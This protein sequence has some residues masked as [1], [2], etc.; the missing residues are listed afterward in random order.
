MTWAD[1]LRR[2]VIAA[3]LVAACGQSASALDST[4]DVGQYAHTAWRFRDGFAQGQVTAIAQTPDGYLWLGSEFGLLRFDGVRSVPWHPPGGER[5]PSNWV[6][7]LLA[8]RDGTLW[9]GTLEGLASWRNGTLTLYPKLAGQSVNA[10]LEDRA[11]TIWAGGYAGG[12][13][14]VLSSTATLC[15]ITNHRTECHGGDFGQW[16]GALHERRN[17][18]LWA[19]AETGLWRLRPGAPKHFAIPESAGSI[20]QTLIDDP[21]GGL[22]VATEDGILQLVDGE[23]IAYRLPGAQSR[24]KPQRLLRDRDGG[25]WIGTLDRGLLHVHQGRTDVYTEANGLSGD[26][27]TR[28]FEDREGNIW[29]AT[30]NGLDRFRELAVRTIST[31]QGLQSAAPW[32]VLAASDGSIWMGTMDGVS[33]WQAGQVTTY[34]TAGNRPAMEVLPATGG[35]ERRDILDSGLPDDKVGALFEDR[36]GR[37]WVSTLRGVAYLAN[38]RFVPVRDLPGGRT[39]LMVGDDAGDLWIVN[40]ALGLFRVRGETVID[41]TPWNTLGLSTPPTALLPDSRHGGLWLGL[42]GRVVYIADTRIRA[43]YAVADG[44]AGGRVNDLRLDANGMLWVA[45]ERGLSRIKDGRVV[46]VTSSNDLPCDAVHWSMEDTDR[47]IWLYMTCGLV[48]IAS[49][50][51]KATLIDPTRRIETRVFAASDGVGL[52]AT[53]A[54]YRPQVARTTDGRLWFLPGDGVSVLDVR[55]MSINTLPPPVHIERVTADR[56]TYAVTSGL[57]LP[58]LTRDLEID[59]TALSF[60]APEMNR[61]RVKLEGRDRHWRDVENRRQVFYTDLSPGAYRFRVAASNNSGVWNETGGVLEFSVAPAY[62][63]TTW[64]QTV[65]VVGAL[66]LCW[67]VYRFR[68]RQLAH[69]FN[70]RLD[71]RVHERTRIAR[72]LHDTLLQSFHGLLLRFQSARDLLPANPGRAVEALDGALDRADQ[73]ITEGRDA[74]QNL[75]SSAAV[76]SELTQAFTALAEELGSHAGGG[77]S[78]AMFRLSVEGRPRELHPIVGDD[79]HRIAREALRNAFYHA[80]A[81][82]IEV[83]VTYGGREL[84]LRIRDDGRGIDLTHLN[85]ERARHWGLTGMRERAGQIG[86]H[87]DLWSEAG[88]GTEVE[89]RVPGALAYRAPH[90]DRHVLRMLRMQ[91][92]GL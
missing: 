63:Q 54:L 85:A 40:D 67:A 79:I 3:G 37:V 90:G 27:I 22:L 23:T 10:L 77:K 74:I 35:A 87:L 66:A 13:G 83:E 50:E 70:L 78:S 11:G 57:Q 9:I 38:G 34:R 29:V 69:D 88:A 72:E 68:L 92:D 59:Y 1:T 53:P 89:L 31:N 7:S 19:T 17:G 51:L 52:R 91:R 41:R 64:F 25:L 36:A 48:R 18:D 82:H 55:N 5:L 62:Y 4:L 56:R 86:A 28:L 16:V 21:D 61:F 73:A 71:E 47:A 42:P 65:G 58:P 44:L 39:S 32:S 6:R 84:R 46:T 15:A 24:F 30:K 75:R 33:R 14:R 76:G 45:M 81:T 12:L 20:L 8:T 2:A 49:A 60:V 43:S 80:Q 26:F